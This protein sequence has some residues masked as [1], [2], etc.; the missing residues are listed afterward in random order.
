MGKGIA[1][2]LAG[3][4]A[5]VLIVARN[6]QKLES[7][8]EDIRVRHTPTLLCP[9]PP[10]LSVSLT[11]IFP[12]GR[13]PHVIPPHS[14][15]T[16]SPPTSPI[17]AL[18]RPPSTKP[19][20]GTMA[21]PR[22][23]Y[24]LRRRGTPRL[25]RRSRPSRLRRADGHQLFLRRLHGACRCKSLASASSYAQKVAHGPR[26]ETHRLYIVVGSV[27]TIYGLHSVY[28]CEMRSAGLERDLEPGV[29]AV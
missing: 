18:L 20:P 26:A 25:F 12:N 4:G 3:K 28:H 9:R 21:P 8:L 22:L 1:Q 23:R 24:L 29:L 15:S 6:V 2:L 19:P 10:S 27:P 13:N 16:S 14:A 11:L 5:N 17:L 7:A